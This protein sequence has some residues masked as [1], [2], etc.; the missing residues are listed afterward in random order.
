MR[1]EARAFTLIELL[2]VIAIIALLMG[3]LLPALNRAREHGKRTACLSN[4]RQLQLAW[5]MYADDN[6]NLIVNG[7]PLG[8]SL[9]EALPPPPGNWAHALFKNEKPWVGYGWGNYAAGG[10]AEQ[11]I[12]EQAIRDGALYRYLNNIKVYRCPTGHRGELITYVI[13]D[14]MNGLPRAGVEAAGFWIKNKLKID[15]PEQRIVFIDEGLLTPDSYAVHYEEE[16]WWDMPRVRHS[17][18]NTM[19][20]ADG[21]AEYWRWEGEKT[22]E[23]GL[24]ADRRQGRFDWTDATEKDYMDLYK[25]QV[26]TYTRLGYTP[27]YQVPVDLLVD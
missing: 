14:S 9:G 6:E 7:A 3:I 17:N 22:V 10:Q 1:R 13:M 4:L 20:F 21:H 18:G 23:N 16:D 2:V 5:I 24:A 27:Q 15:R 11:Y 12:Q 19:S 26:G 25:I 8:I